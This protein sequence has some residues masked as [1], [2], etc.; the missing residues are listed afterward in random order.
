MALLNNEMNKRGFIFEG[1][2]RWP[3]M[4]FV[5]LI[6]EYLYLISLETVVGYIRSFQGIQ[7]DLSVLLE[8]LYV[9]YPSRNS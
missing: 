3:V 6:Q 8:E 1:M 4:N 9:T 7:F 2:R 5:T